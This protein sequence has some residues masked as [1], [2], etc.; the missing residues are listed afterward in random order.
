MFG[1][2]PSRIHPRAGPWDSPK[3]VTRKSEP[4]VFPGIGYSGLFASVLG[5]GEFSF[6]SFPGG[7][8]MA[9]GSEVIQD[10]FQFARFQVT[11]KGLDEVLV[12]IQEN[13]GWE[14]EA[15]V[16]PFSG[17]FMAVSPVFAFKP[18]CFIFKHHI[19]IL[20]GI[21]FYRVKVG[22]HISCHSRIDKGS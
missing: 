9:V 19:F 8:S 2:Q 1:G 10:G 14:A 15:V 20:F 11:G 21:E 18:V 3:V 22:I 16:E 13:G 5:A 7:C 6:V 4:K 17:Q 12:F